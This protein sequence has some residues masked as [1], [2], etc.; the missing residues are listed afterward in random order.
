[1]SRR[2]L[3]DNP[4]GNQDDKQRLEKKHQDVA[5]RAKDSQYSEP[6]SQ[7]GDESPVPIWIHQAREGRRRDLRTERKHEP[8]QR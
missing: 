8:G 7:G 2:E 6:E 3:E 1:M 4:H 5:T